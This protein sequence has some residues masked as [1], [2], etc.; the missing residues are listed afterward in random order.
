MMGLYLNRQDR[1]FEHFSRPAGLNFSENRAVG[2]GVVARDWDADGDEDL[3]VA[4]GHVHYRPDRGTMPQ[5]PMLLENVDGQ[6]LRRVSIDD[7]FFQQ[8]RVGRG[9]A[10]ADFDSDGDSDI[11][12]TQLD[13]PPSLVENHCPAGR[14]HWLRIRLI[15]TRTA[16]Q[17]IGTRVLLDWPGGT[18]MRQL[19]GGGSYLSDSEPVLEFAW[20]RSSEQQPPTVRLR[21][22]W[23][24][25]TVTEV[26]QA[27]PDQTLT[28]VQP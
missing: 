16:R 8:P 13:G 10:T 22:E 15:G 19:V 28:L 21:I 6:T 24:D 23:T 14:H 9:L 1:F 25:G 20:P 26:A 27:N 7:P 4:C 2:F 18:M 12:A 17:P 11:V 3:L 5:L